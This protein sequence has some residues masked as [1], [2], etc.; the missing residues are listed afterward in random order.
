MSTYLASPIARQLI[1]TGANILAAF[2]TQ[3]ADW[4]P[5]SMLRA[6]SAAGFFFM[7]AERLSNIPLSAKT[8]RQYLWMAADTLTKKTDSEGEALDSGA[9]RSAQRQNYKTL[10]KVARAVIGLVTA[11]G[12]SLL[13]NRCNPSKISAK[14]V[15]AFSAIPAALLFMA[16]DAPRRTRV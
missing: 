5:Q 7:G 10:E 9:I 2:A 14:A 13:F 15:V 1:G 16:P 11:V 8:V 3:K 12:I 4:H 6:A